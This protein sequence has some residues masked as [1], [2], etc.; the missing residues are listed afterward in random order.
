MTVAGGVV[1]FTQRE[2]IWLERDCRAVLDR[3]ADEGCWTPLEISDPEPYL[4]AI[5][6]EMGEI[7]AHYV[8]VSRRLTS[9]SDSRAPLTRSR[10]CERMYEQIVYDVDDPVA[11]I[12]L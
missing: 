4:P 2:D 7:G 3:L 5:G 8:C 10:S 11:T 9:P 12:T 1:A 6:D